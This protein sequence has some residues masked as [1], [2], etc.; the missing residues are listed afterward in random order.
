MSNITL[1]HGNCLDKM[2]QIP[3]GSIDLIL[4]DLPYGVTK[5]KWDSVIPFE[6]LWQRYERII[7]SNGAIVLFGQGLFSAKL[8]LSN[9]KLYRYSLV[10][11]KT[12][13]TGHLNAGKMPLRSHEDI[14]V[15]YKSQPTYNPQKTF[16]HER[17]VS[18]AKQ[19]DVMLR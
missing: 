10:W 3:D 17:K 11:E 16:G 6:S 9:E 2:N 19:R 13:P 12:T 18:S 5:N 7:K 4:C 14:L 8:M 1:M 15:F